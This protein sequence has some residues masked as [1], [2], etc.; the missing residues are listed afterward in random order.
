MVNKP[1]EQ[2]TNEALAKFNAAR[3][4]V[5]RR[6]GN[7]NDHAREPIRGRAPQVE[8]PLLEH[9]DNGPERIIAAP[10][11]WR[12]PST[13]QPRRWVYGKHYIRQFMTTT[14][15]PGGTGKSSLALVEAVAMVTGRNLIGA[16]SR[17]PLVV[18]YWN[19]EDPREEI[20]RRLAAICKHFNISA[21]DIGGRLY[22][23]SGRDVRIIVATRLRDQTNIA[24][25]MVEGLTRELREKHVDCLTLD[26]FVSTHS[27]PEND[28]GAIEQVA[29]AYAGIADEAN[30]AVELPH[31]TRKPP[32]GGDGE[33]TVDDGRGASALIAKARS[34]RVLNVMSK[35]DAD[36]VGVAADQRSLYFR[37]DNG[38]ANM[39]PPAEKARWCKLVSV[40][41]GNAVGDEPEDWVQVAT[42]WEMPGA[43]DGVTTAHLAQVVAKVQAGEYR[44]DLRAAAWVGKA[45][46]DVLELDIADEAAKRRVNAIL[47]GWFGNKVL[48]K[49]P[50]YDGNR[51]PVDFVGVGPGLEDESGLHQS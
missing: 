30:C 35:A 1:P 31:H 7:G 19:G 12:D 44:A 8:R 13:I 23:N 40:P 18:W 24:V 47:K 28:N 10:W 48:V 9:P 3:A 29:S 14:V 26:P 39:Q 32:P 27:V 15:A 4:A 42:K 45:V 20:D 11:I 36:N 49:R 50:G 38:K 34:A 5:A 16:Q 22:V 46:A 17:T 43:F 6:N 51:K 37:I 33:R 2:V 25:P 41:L 21:A